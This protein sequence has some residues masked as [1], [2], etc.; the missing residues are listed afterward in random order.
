M[1]CYNHHDRDAF[2]VCQICGKGLC[3]ECMDKDKDMVVCANEHKKSALYNFILNFL[4]IVV[5]I[6]CFVSAYNDNFDWFRIILG[7]LS[8]SIGVDGFRKAKRKK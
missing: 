6:I 3:L 7:I 1:K 5:A 2:G 8:L 4:F